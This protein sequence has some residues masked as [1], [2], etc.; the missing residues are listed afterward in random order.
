MV[1]YYVK[2]ISRTVITSCARLTRRAFFRFPEIKEMGER[3]AR[4]PAGQHGVDA[5]ASVS[6]E[7]CCFMSG[8]LATGDV[9][10]RSPSQRNITYLA[11]AT[12]NHLAQRYVRDDEVTA[13]KHR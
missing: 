9:S 2:A 1:G 6:C 5:G 3:L 13:I 12:K 4:A 8:K 11:S 7:R 10:V